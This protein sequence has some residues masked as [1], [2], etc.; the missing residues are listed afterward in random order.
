M[1]RKVMAVG[2]GLLPAPRLCSS[3][4]ESRTSQDKRYFY[5]LVYSSL[6]SEEIPGWVEKLLKR[7]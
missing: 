7:H 2:G 5:D 4:L 1:Q 3:S 6:R